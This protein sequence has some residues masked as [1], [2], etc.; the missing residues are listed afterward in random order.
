M[1]TRQFQAIFYLI[2]GLCILTMVVSFTSYNFIEL[3]TAVSWTMKYFALPILILMI[4]SCYFIYLRF[5]RQHETKEYKSKIW[6]QLRTVLRIFILTLATTG[7][8]IG[9]TLSMIILT[10]AY[11][12]DSKTIN[13]NAKIVDYYTLTNNKGTIRH[14]IKIQDQQ[15]D[16]IIDLKVQGPYQVGQTFNKTMQIGKWG[17][18]YSEK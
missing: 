9:T 12:G 5:I 7:I 2:L 1:T 17:L 16:R 8:L 14:Y 18:L 11:I 6:T 13:L 3:D 15:L 4:P 10:N